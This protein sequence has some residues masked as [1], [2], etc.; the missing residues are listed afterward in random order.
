MIKNRIEQLASI[1]IHLLQII[2]LIFY[3]IPRHHVLIL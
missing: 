2:D 3:N 1:H